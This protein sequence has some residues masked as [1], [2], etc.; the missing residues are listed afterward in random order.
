[1]PPT[2]LEFEHPDTHQ[3]IQL[4]QNDSLHCVPA[5]TRKLQQHLTLILNHIVHI[6]QGPCY[7]LYHG[8]LTT[9]GQDMPVVAKQSRVEGDVL[10]FVDQLKE[11]AATYCH[12]LE[13]C[14]GDVVPLFYGLYEGKVEGRPTM[15][16]L[17]EDCGDPCD[18]N[19][20]SLDLSTK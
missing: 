14:Q 5:V 18:D 16:M 4:I 19:L 7:N 1:M 12:D 2:Q 17:L 10:E 15:C 6:E 3:T 8:I 11:E 13:I 20:E 9:P